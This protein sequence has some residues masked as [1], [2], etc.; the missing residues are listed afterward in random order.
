MAYS[1][2]IDANVTSLL[3]GIILYIF[4]SGPIQGFATT[5]I[6]G[7]LTSLFSAIFLT[8]LVFEWR[9]EKNK[10]LTFFTKYTEGAF[11][12]INVDWIGKR[13]I[14]YMISGTIILIGIGSMVF[15]GF[16]TGV[17]F[18]G[19]RSYV[20]RFDQPVSSVD[21]RS[22]LAAPF[23]SAP[24][25]KTFGAS[26]QVKITTSYLIEDNT[27]EAD[28]KVEDALT[29]SLGIDMSRI[30]SSQKVGATIADDI[31]LSAVYSI[32]IALI[33]IFLYILLRFRKWTFG[34][35]ALA[36]LAHDVLI[37]LSIFS[38]FWGILP[39][40]LEIDQA[41]IA[42]IL[43]VV[44]YSIND[45]VI[46]FDRVREFLG[47]HHKTEMK[48]VVNSA[49]NATISRTINTS[50]TTMF[51]LFAIFIFGGEV[52]RGFAFALLIGIG[53]GTYSSLCIATPIV[54]D[55]TKDKN[56]PLKK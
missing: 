37:L 43:T 26:N 52:I 7:I 16:S 30:M 53:V 12:N 29:S 47:I 15:R 42:A 23:G 35:G 19:G 8:R 38:I 22:K 17:D 31:K 51:V 55:L 27:I 18:K 50:L 25:V 11:K 33:V 4:G 44:G 28:Q 3:T 36:A 2:I 20:V 54:V 32:V 13:K 34:T 9:L 39:F 10:S 5:L 56:E 49:L 46:V 48:K 40:S 6:I 41:F 1:S 14:F 45:T 21:I 24:E